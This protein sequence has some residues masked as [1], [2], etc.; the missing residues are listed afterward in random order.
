MSLDNTIPEARKLIGQQIKKQRQELGLSRNAVASRC[1][2][3][4]NQVKAIEDGS[5]AYTIDALLR[6][7]HGMGCLF[8]I[9]IESRENSE[10][11]VPPAH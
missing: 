7:S 8:F 9:T 10:H 6:L 1:G 2:L 11:T 3:H 4:G 5:T